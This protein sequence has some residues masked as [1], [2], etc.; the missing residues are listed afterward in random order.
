MNVI[1]HAVAGAIL[2]LALPAFSEE[3]I[4]PVP[5]STVIVNNQGEGIGYALFRQLQEGVEISLTVQN[6]KPGPRGM[7]LHEKGNC[8]DI[9]SFQ[10]SGGHIMHQEKPHGLHH[11]EGP[12]GGDLPNLDV[13]EDGTAS[14][15]LVTP[16][17]SLYEHATLPFLLDE[18][19]S[20]LIIHAEKD[21]QMT[22]PIGGAGAR[23][24]CGAI[25]G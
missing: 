24:A 6:L 2:L 1:P 15:T 16:R 11:P 9:I 7:H 10:N 25:K 21:D 20:A 8:D 17:V 3:K 5:V 12:D 23:V 14:L 18:D 4:T 19:G 13:R 22:Q